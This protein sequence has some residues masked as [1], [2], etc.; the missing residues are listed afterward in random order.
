MCIRRIAFP[1][2]FHDIPRHLTSTGFDPRPL[3]ELRVCTA[4][5]AQ[6]QVLLH[7]HAT[8]SLHSPRLNILHCTA[9]TEYASSATATSPGVK[10]CGCALE[11]QY[12][13]AERSLRTLCP[14][15][16]PCLR[17]QTWPCIATL[18]MSPFS[19][20]IRSS[21]TSFKFQCEPEPRY[22][23]LACT[24]TNHVACAINTIQ[25]AQVPVEASALHTGYAY[26]AT[27]CM[28][29]YAGYGRGFTVC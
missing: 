11:R 8:P 21:Q 17:P 19:N 23:A 24:N 25:T 10:G 5:A 9:N 22:S 2:P 1:A 20:P 14:E 13:Y 3:P 27:N 7:R 4:N 18:Q 15:G 29:S 6:G 26:L 28:C 16:S 12:A